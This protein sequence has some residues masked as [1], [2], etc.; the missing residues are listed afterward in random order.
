MTDQHGN[1]VPAAMVFLEVDPSALPAAV[2]S[3]VCGIDWYEAADFPGVVLVDPAAL[4]EALG[5]FAHLASGRGKT[6]RQFYNYNR[7]RDVSYIPAANRRWSGARGFY[8]SKRV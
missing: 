3:G 2:A 1:P 4:A 7:D 5:A 8:N 6:V